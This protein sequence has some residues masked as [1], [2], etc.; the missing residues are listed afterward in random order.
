MPGIEEMRATCHRLITELS[1]GAADHH[2]LLEIETIIRLLVPHL[3]RAIAQ[4]IQ[5]E[6][7]LDGLK[8]GAV[9]L[10]AMQDRLMWVQL[11]RRQTD[12]SLQD[13]LLEAAQDAER[14]LAALKQHPL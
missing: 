1:Q 12:A 11:G 14:V 10:V 5:H 9:A 7:Q 4:R 3:T 2:R 6:G 8:T 13:T